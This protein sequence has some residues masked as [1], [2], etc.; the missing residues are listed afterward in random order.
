MPRLAC[1]SNTAQR[2]VALVFM[3]WVGAVWTVGF[4]VVPRLFSGLPPA[5]AGRLAAGLFAF[6][7]GA[8]LVILPLTLWLAWSW[9]DRLLLGVCWLGAALSYWYLGPRLVFLA[10]HGERGPALEH[11]HAMATVD[12]GLCAVGAAVL[13]WRLMPWARVPA[14]GKGAPS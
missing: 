11:L 13:G 2:L 8:A 7:N 9:L 6:V 3:V 12:Y 1:L 5:E 14:T 10:T 4:L